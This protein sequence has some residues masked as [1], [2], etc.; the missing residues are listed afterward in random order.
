MS[1]NGSAVIV[2]A[3]VVVATPVPATVIIGNPAAVLPHVV[4]VPHV[5]ATNDVGE[6]WSVAGT[7]VK[8][9]EL[10]SVVTYPTSTLPFPI[11]VANVL[12]TLRDVPEVQ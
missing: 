2:A 3:P 1:V 7:C 5:F 4:V 9:L 8:M 10:P 6:I 11:A 12:V